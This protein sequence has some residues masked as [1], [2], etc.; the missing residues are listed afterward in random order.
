MT[1]S[2]C[3]SVF[4][5]GLPSLEYEFAEPPATVYPRIRAAQAQAPMALGPYGPEILSHETGA[6]RSA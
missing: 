2:L 4:D 1:T 6:D 3:P 5:A